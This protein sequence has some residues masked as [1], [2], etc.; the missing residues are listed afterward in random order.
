MR[1]L[2]ILCLLALAATSAPGCG[3]QPTDSE[4]IALWQG[5]RYD[6]EDLS[7]RIAYLRSAVSAPA[8]DG[9]LDAQLGIIGG[10]FS[11]GGFGSD[12]PSWT[13]SWM[14]VDS[15]LIQVAEQ[16]VTFAIGPDGRTEQALEIDLAALGL[17]QWP[18]HHVVLRGV[19][20]DTDV[21]PEPG[22]DPS[23]DVSHGW[24]PQALGAG[25]SGTPERTGDTLAVGAWMEFKAGPL[26][27]P[28]MNASVPFA[29]VAGVL[30]LS[31]IGS[32][33]V[34]SSG[35]LQAD[36]Y[37]LRDAPY[38]VIEPLPVADRTLAIAGT[39]DQPVGI[40]LLY[41]WRMELNESIGLEGRYLRAFGV[42]LES[43]SYD[44]ASGVGTG[45]WDLFC[46]HSSLVEE[47]D[48]EV[49]FEVQ[50]GMLQ[51]PGEGSAELITATSDSGVGPEVWSCDA[52][53]ACTLIES[54]E[55]AE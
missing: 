43:W 33:A 24:T 28:P 4:P 55:P 1:T 15:D 52:A 36:D 48:L 27:R 40:P 45:V 5:V 53:G 20:Y 29:N 46:S 16:D 10:N 11:T 23:Y 39:E 17:D 51:P 9:S 32:R 21:P 54:A 22:A 2:P 14:A 37:I 19:T 13:M 34:A 38:T 30:H 8:A 26:D 12:I 3:P 44:A 42:R 6:W 31:V 41:G 47:G 7:H 18:N 50:A 25:L 35:S 49:E